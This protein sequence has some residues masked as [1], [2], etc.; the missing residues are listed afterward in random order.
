MSQTSMWRRS[1]YWNDYNENWNNDEENETIDNEKPV[2]TIMRYGEEEAVM[3]IIIQWPASEEIP[4]RNYEIAK[5]YSIQYCN[6][7]IENI[8]SKQ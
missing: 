8:K 6:Q 2:M 3:Y 4:R 1:N 5:K 7:T